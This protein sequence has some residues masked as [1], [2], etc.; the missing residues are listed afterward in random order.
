MKVVSIE[1]PPY[2]M[3]GRGIPVLTI[4]PRLMAILALNCIKR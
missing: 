3:N 4:R 2:D 1:L